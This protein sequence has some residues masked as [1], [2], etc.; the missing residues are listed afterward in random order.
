MPL[1][2]LKATYTNPKYSRKWLQGKRAVAFGTKRPGQNHLGPRALKMNL[3]E[4]RIGLQTPLRSLVHG[5]A[6]QSQRI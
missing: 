4:K 3:E 5:H 6:E 1:H 2:E